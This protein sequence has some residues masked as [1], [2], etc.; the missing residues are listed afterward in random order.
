MASVGWCR[1]FSGHDMG[2][3]YGSSATSSVSLVINL[4]VR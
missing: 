3:E 2:K 4:V 1:E